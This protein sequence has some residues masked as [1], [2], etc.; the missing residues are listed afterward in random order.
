MLCMVITMAPAMAWAE[1]GTEAEVE[2]VKT[3]LGTSVE[4]TLSDGE[5]VSADVLCE[6]AEAALNE[7]LGN[8]TEYAGYSTEVSYS[9]NRSS[10]S[11]NGY[12]K[13]YSKAGF[14]VHVKK[15]GITVGTINPFAISVDRTPYNMTLGYPG[16][17]AKVDPLKDLKILEIT[18]SVTWSVDESGNLVQSNVKNGNTSFFTIASPKGDKHFHMEATRGEYNS[19]GTSE[20]DLLLG[21][22]TSRSSI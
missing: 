13:T 2:A 15:D 19:D 3:L 8:S 18:G 11:G 21:D 10:A 6:L 16:G 9:V 4:V 20:I 7:K 14:Q 1:T 12:G 17:F 22:S 5:S